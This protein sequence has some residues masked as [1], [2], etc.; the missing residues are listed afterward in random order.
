MPGSRTPVISF[1][2]TKGGVGKTTLT[3]ALATGMVDRLSGKSEYRI[4]CIDADPNTT[5]DIALRRAEAPEIVSMVSDAETM[6]QTLR[7]AERMADIV[8]IDL[9]GSANQSMLYAVGKS[10]LVIIPAQP[11]AFDVRE[12]LK[13]ANVVQ[14]ASDL[15]GHPIQVRVVLTRTPPLKQRVTEHSRAQFSKS[16]LTLLPVELVHRVAFQNMSYTGMP[17]HQSE[18][19]GNAAQNVDR[20][21]EAIAEL[22]DLP[23]VARP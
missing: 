17:P 8:L 16:G 7:D 13:T 3:L 12:A 20:L 14:Q 1:A 22:V 10:D 19:G 6:L 15:V 18:P 4:A 21:V 23:L 5:L 2:S 9:E 11:S